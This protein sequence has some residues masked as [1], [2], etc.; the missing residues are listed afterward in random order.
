MKEIGSKYDILIVY[1]FGPDG[2]FCVLCLEQKDLDHHLQI[3]V[4]RK[5][6]PDLQRGKNKQQKVKLRPNQLLQKLRQGVIPG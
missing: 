1:S 3:K 5:G 2:D 4:Q 6:Q